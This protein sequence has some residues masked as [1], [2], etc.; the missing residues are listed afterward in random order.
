MGLAPM[1]R[2]VSPLVVHGLECYGAEPGPGEIVEVWRVESDDRMVYLGEGRLVAWLQRLRVYERREDQRSA[3]YF[4]IEG[5]K[6]KASRERDI[7][8]PVVELVWPDPPGRPPETPVYPRC[9]DCRGD[10]GLELSGGD[11]GV[12]Q[13]LGDAKQCGVCGG[14]G[15]HDDWGGS[16]PACDG[17]GWT[18]REG[19]G[20]LFVDTRDAAAGPVPVVAD[21]PPRS[22]RQ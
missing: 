9:P 4:V 11:A 7:R 3:P 18:P 16:C 13:C 2:T 1:R 20:S 15:E 12:M 10:L 6:R 22:G 8:M 5:S 17:S 19:C 14:M 21:P